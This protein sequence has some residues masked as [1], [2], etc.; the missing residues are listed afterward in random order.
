MNNRRTYY[1]FAK[2]YDEFM[3]D[4]PYVDW[5]EMIDDYLYSNGYEDSQILELGCGT[6]R[7]TRMLAIDR[8]HL[9]GM[10]LS[11]EMIRIAN[12]N[13]KGS[14]VRY[15]VGDMRDFHCKNKYNVVL[16]IC[17]SMN[18]LLNDDDLERTFSMVKKYL[19]PGGIFIFDMKTKAFFERL[20]NNV[21]T[22]ECEIGEYFWENDYD[23]RTCNN[24]YYISFF[25]KK[26][27]LY[28]KFVEEHTQH[29]FTREEVCLAAVKNGFR[30]RSV[31]GMDFKS[32]A[33]FEKDRVYFILEV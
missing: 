14:D 1:G 21:F 7:F 8:Y 13:K 33:D 5:V 12:K 29:A 26:G 25:I 16:S 20:G 10:D 11:P 27:R 17:D 22:D 15:F 19:L 9:T 3:H 30:I 32:E 31:L 23:S 18:Y 2:V 24:E 4:I 28:R 6:G